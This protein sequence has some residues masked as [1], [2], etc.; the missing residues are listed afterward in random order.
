MLS[1][2]PALENKSENWKKELLE[3]V[4]LLYIEEN[5]TIATM[6]TCKNNTKKKN[7]KKSSCSS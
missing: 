5:I 2:K 4:E 6:Q 1:A 7:R 3:N